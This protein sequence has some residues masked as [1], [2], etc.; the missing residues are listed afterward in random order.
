MMAIDSLG[1]SIRC[2]RWSVG[3]RRHHLDVDDLVVAWLIKIRYFSRFPIAALL[4]QPAGRLVVLPTGRLDQDAP[5]TKPTDA[6]LGKGHEL[7][8][9][10]LALRLWIDGNP[11]EIVH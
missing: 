1:R 7:S 3:S 11:I 8:P 9:H 4:I 2:T 5:S 6:F 10:A